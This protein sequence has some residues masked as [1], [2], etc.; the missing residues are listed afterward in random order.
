MSNKLKAAGFEGSQSEVITTVL[1][2]V[3]SKM[4]S[5]EQLDAK[6]DSLDA[7]L[8]ATDANFNTKLDAISKA[9]DAKFDKLTEKSD[10][11]N[12]LTLM[13]LRVI[14]GIFFVVLGLSL[15]NEFQDK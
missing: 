10:A 14:F 7:K 15:K 2:E 12:K 11:T 1:Q 9:M 6:F 8:K 5:S 3:V 4:A 13:L